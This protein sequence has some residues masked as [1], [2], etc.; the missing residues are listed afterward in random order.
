MKT[1]S[2]S[3]S[4][5]DHGMP[6]YTASQMKKKTRRMI[7]ALRLAD[8]HCEMCGAE[9][10]PYTPLEVYHLDG[11]DKSWRPDLTVILCPS[12]KAPSMRIWPPGGGWKNGTPKWAIRR[13]I[14]RA[15]ERFAA[16]R[17]PAGR[18]RGPKQ[19]PTAKKET[20]CQESS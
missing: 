19:K 5:R 11:A 10:N 6:G 8:Y 20:I 4:L 1:K 16:V 17:G 15:V 12:C 7:K 9:D 18:G 13:G 3:C 2:S 14:F